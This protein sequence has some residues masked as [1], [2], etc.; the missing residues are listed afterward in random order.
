MDQ[1]EL[2]RYTILTLESLAIPYMLVGSYASTTYGEPRMTQDIDIVLDLN[3]ARIPEF[4]RAFP[5]P[6]FYLSEPA[7]RDAVKT[8]FQ[9]NILHPTS[10]V[11]IDVILPRNDEWGREQ[12]RRRRK[13]AI[14]PDL[15]GTIASPEDVILG[16][17]WYHSEGGSDK[18]IRDIVGML[19]TTENPIDRD[20]IQQWVDKLGFQASWA[21]I[22]ERLKNE[23]SGEP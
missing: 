7:I 8:R 2:L 20:T 5:P 17:L 3:E 16:K 6:Q 23:P 11:K 14:L 22:L 13:L 1:L 15:I 18:H 4:C 19:R 9:F 12:L 10:G 21:T